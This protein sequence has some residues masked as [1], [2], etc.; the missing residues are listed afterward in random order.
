MYLLTEIDFSNIGFMT[1][2]DFI[3][4][5]Y[6]AYSVYTA[7]QMKKTNEPPQW[8]VPLQDIPRVHNKEKFCTEMYPRTLIFGVVCIAYGL[9]GL[10]EWFYI[11]RDFWEA[12]GVTIF[13]IFVIWFIITLQNTKRRYIS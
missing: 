4:L 3:I 12:F 11:Q 9:Y 6:G 8:L 2:F 1:I 5:I 7:Q 10:I 13:V